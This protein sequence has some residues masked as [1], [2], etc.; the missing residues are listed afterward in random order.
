MDTP[1]NIGDVMWKPVCNPRE[2]DETCPTCYGA[3]RVTI[4]LGNNDEVDI[5]CDGCGKGDEGP[6]GVVHG[7]SYEPKAVRFEIKAVHSMYNGEWTLLSTLGDMANYHELYTTGEEALVVSIK[8]MQACVDRNMRTRCA[9]T[10][11]Q[12]ENLTWQVQYHEKCIKDA[13]RQIAWHRTKV[14]LRRKADPTK[15]PRKVKA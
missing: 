12:R 14:S 8:E 1:F 6:R 10:K 3:L 5:A 13:E 7:Y 15:P 9:Q 4:T 2:V 11:H